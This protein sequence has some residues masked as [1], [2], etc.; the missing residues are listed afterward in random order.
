MLV[1]ASS[2]LASE[3]RTTDITY[4]IA[5]KPK[6]RKSLSRAIQVRSFNLSKTAKL[7]QSVKLN[8]L[9]ENLAKIVH[10]ASSRFGGSDS[11]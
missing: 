1:Y 7:V 4:G 9:S 2:M 5:C 3:R 10:A 6:A 8:D 11:A